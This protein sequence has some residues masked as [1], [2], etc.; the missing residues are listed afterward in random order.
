MKQ[1][2]KY[3][4]GCHIE[5]DTIAIHVFREPNGT[6][7]AAYKY[8]WSMDGEWADIEVLEA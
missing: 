2:G 4:Y 3:L 5:R 8:V 6:I 7:I 1:E